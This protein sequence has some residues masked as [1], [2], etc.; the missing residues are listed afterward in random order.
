MRRPPSILTHAW[1]GSCTKSSHSRTDVAVVVAAFAAGTAAVVVAAAAAAAAG[2]AVA[3][4]VD[5]FCV[6]F[7]SPFCFGEEE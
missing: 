6:L 4:A 5:V 3:V 7:V 1:L 2:A